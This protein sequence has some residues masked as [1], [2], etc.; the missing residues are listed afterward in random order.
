[1]PA[2]QLFN[3]LSRLGQI[4]VDRIRVELIFLGLP[5]TDP[6][7]NLVVTGLEFNQLTQRDESY[8][9]VRFHS[10]FTIAPICAIKSFYWNW[11]GSHQ[12]PV[13]SRTELRICS[14]ERLYTVTMDTTSFSPS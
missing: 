1:M 2:V 14:L 5:Q 6:I 11:L 8:T 3:E 7:Y 12:Q 13:V 4:L 10:A 9:A